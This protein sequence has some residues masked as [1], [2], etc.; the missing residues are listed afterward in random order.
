MNRRLLVIIPCLFLYPNVLADNVIT[1]FLR[2]YPIEMATDFAQET[3][4]KLAYPKKLARRH[5]E[6]II[7]RNII[8]GIFSTYAGFIES[9]DVNGQ[10][11]FP[12]KHAPPKI[13]L[14]VATKITPVMLF[15]QT[16]HHWELEE[17][18]PTAMYTM[19]Q[20]QDKDTNQFYWKVQ[21]T[22][23]PKDY[24]IPLESIIIIAKP[25]Y[26]YIP[27]GITLTDDSPNLTLPNIY[28]KK[29]INIIANSLYMLNLM[30]LFRPPTMLYKKG[31]KNYEELVS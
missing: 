23:T 12:R 26:I 17:I 5:I 7:G 25:H 14:I 13:K 18:V 20:E 6:G 16:V 31:T 4:K 27:T 9:S 28:V 11:L 24:L 2:P 8:A 29:G 1:F 30:H 21:K 22:E 10:I 15:S 19:E 3:A